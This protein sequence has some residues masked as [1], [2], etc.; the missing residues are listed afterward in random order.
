MAVKL[1]FNLVIVSAN[2]ELIVLI[3]AESEDVS[4]VS[5]YQTMEGS[6]TNENGLAV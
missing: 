2:S 5:S 4:F 3:L 1:V 6:T